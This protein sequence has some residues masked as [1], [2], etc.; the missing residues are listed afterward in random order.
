MTEEVLPD[1]KCFDSN[2][3][4]IMEELLPSRI[5]LLDLIT[6]AR[7]FIKQQ[8]LLLLPM[9]RISLGRESYPIQR[10]SQPLLIFV[11]MRSISR[12]QF[13]DLLVVQCITHVC[14]LEEIWECKR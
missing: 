3:S 1:R 2:M 5:I 12:R 7:L 4:K 10:L 8:A 13:L 14:L 6:L 11:D 9:S